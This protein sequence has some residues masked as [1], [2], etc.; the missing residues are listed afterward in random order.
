[1]ANEYVI[2]LTEDNFEE[3]TAQGVALVDF[4]ADW[5][6]P[7]HMVAP[8]VDELATEYNERAKICKLNVDDQES[9]AAAFG[10]MSIPTLVVLKDGVEAERIVG[11]R[12]KNDL[13][14]M[15]EKYL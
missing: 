12:P 15:I 6:G 8:S 3:Q 7:C 13:A 10:V 2:S 11:V 4:W 5:C 14:A 1:M 9:L